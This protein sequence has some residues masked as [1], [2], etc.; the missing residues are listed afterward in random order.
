MFLLLRNEELESK[1]NYIKSNGKRNV[2]LDERTV[3]P[4]SSVFYVAMNTY[5]GT[6]DI[7][8][9]LQTHEMLHIFKTATEAKR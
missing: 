6:N 1:S 9:F 7:R 2:V 3:M 5:S 8:D 4:Q